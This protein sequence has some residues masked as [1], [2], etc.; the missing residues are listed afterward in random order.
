[1]NIRAHHFIKFIEILLCVLLSH[2]FQSGML[3]NDKTKPNQP[4]PW[5]DLQV[6][7]YTGNLFYQRSDLLIPTRGEIPLH[8]FFSYNSLKHQQDNGYGNGWSFCFGMFYEEKGEDIIIYREEGEEDIF[9]WDST[10]FVPPIGVYDSLTEYDT[11]KYILRTKHGIKYYF[12]SS[13]HKRLTKIIDRNGNT[14]TITYT[15]GRPTTITDPAGRLLTLSWTGEHLSQVTDPNTTPSRIFTYQYDT[16]WN[17]VKVTWPLSNIY[18]YGYDSSG[19]LTSVTDPRS[20]TVTISYDVNEAVSGLS[21]I[22]VNYNK[23]FVY[24]NCN[25]TT[26]VNQIVST[27]SRLTVYTY[28]LT[29][30][31][32]GILNPDSSLIYY[33]WDSLNNVTSF[34]NENGSSTTYTHDTKGNLMSET[35]CMGGT[36]SHTYESVFNK[37]TSYKDKRGYL[38]TYGYD[39]NGN[40]TSIMDCYNNTETFTFNSYGNVIS[41]KDKNNKTTTFSYDTYGNQT[42]LTDPL[43]F[44]ETRTYDLTGNML[45]YTDKR[46]KATTYAYD[47]LDRNTGITDAL[48]YT[49]SFTY[50]AN[51]NLTGETNQNSKTTSYAYDPLNRL[52]VITD[53]LG[54]TLTK[55]YDEAGN[56]ISKTNARGFTTSFTFNSRDWLM[57]VTDCLGNSESRTYNTAGDML[58]ST[59]KGGNTTTFTCNCLR[60]R[61]GMIDPNGFTE[62]YA[63]DA[64]GNMTGYTNKKGIPT[65]SV[66]DGLNRMTRIDYAL[67]FTELFAFDP[68]GN[69]TGFTDKN[70]NTIT[71][72]LDAMGRITTITDPLTKTESKAYDGE[73]NMT[74]YTD[75]NGNTTTF[76]YD[77]LGRLVLKTDPLPLGYTESHTYDGVGNMLTSTDR[78]GNTTSRQYDNLNR[79]T[80]MTTPKGY[81][82]ITTYDAIGNRTSFINKN[83]DTTSYTYDCLDRQITTTDPMGNTQISGFNPDGKL[84]SL[85]DKNGNTT[86]WN[87]NCCRLLST[88]DP[89]LFSEYYGYDNFGNMTSLTNKNLNIT[90]YAYDSLNR[91]TTI[92]T[93]MGNQ[94]KDSL[95]GNGNILTKI[96]A[97]LDTINYTYN[98][99]NELIS[100]QYPDGTSVSY[101]YNNNGDLLQSVNTGGIGETI[102]Y[103]Y[104]IYG[105]II[106]KVTNYGTFSKTITHTRDRNGNNLSIISEAGTISY[107]YDADNRITQITDQ[108]GG[109]TTFQCDGMGNPTVVNYPNGISTF[110]T[111]DA[112]GN[113]ISVVTQTTPS[114]P[115]GNP[116]QKSAKTKIESSRE[117]LEGIDYAVVEIISPVSGPGLSEEV[118][119]I[120]NVMNMGTV[121]LPDFVVSYTLDDTIAFTEFVTVPIPLGGF[122]VHTFSQ[123]VDLS[124]PGN[125]YELTACV[126]ATGD[127]YPDNDCMITSITNEITITM[128]QAFNYIYDFNGNKTMETRLDGTNILFEYSNRNEL[129]S[130]Y[131]LT[132]GALNEFTFYPGGQKHTMTVNGIVEYHYLY[133]P[134]GAMLS[135]GDLEFTADNMGNRTSVTD[136][137]GNVIGYSFGYNYDLLQVSFPDGTASYYAYSAQGDKLQQIENGIT[138]Y[139]HCLEKE[140]L[141]E[142]DAAGNPTWV[143]N[144]RLSLT[145]GLATGYYYY[146]GHGTSTLQMDHFQTVLATAFYDSYGNITDSSGTFLQDKEI[147]KSTTYEPLLGIFTYSSYYLPAPWLYDPES[148]FSLNYLTN[149]PEMGP[150]TPGIPYGPDGS[151]PKPGPD[152]GTP[153]DPGGSDPRFDPRGVPAPKPEPVI[154]RCCCCV[155]DLRTPLNVTKTSNDNAFFIKFDTEIDL[156]YKLWDRNYDGDC[157]LEWWE[158]SNMAYT[159]DMEPNTW[160]DMTQDPEMESTFK[161]WKCRDNNCP[162][163]HKLTVI[164]TD[165]PGWPKGYM[166]RETASLVIYFEITVKSTPG[167][168]CDYL[169]MSNYFTVTHE[170]TWGTPGKQEKTEGVPST[171]VR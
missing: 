21:C 92:T 70:G 62:T 109:V 69:Q 28:D 91:L 3:A 126:M 9:T 40:L 14:S 55:T 102:N 160:T 43:T 50:D 106:S 74:S 90:T 27:V 49:R 77:N 137:D 114:P 123:F 103:T 34:T 100:T 13:T 37:M 117:I 10:A 146:N 95:D 56:I 144:P 73:G 89:L 52:S 111:Y 125:T 156:E 119:V 113:V 78:R 2:C 67:G 147:F 155:N 154:P 93:P 129:I 140:V 83:G 26:S 131:N 158:K 1:M 79:Q 135:A 122:Y 72:T 162:P 108:N 157:T 48:N 75:K 98:A 101:S 85:K 17:L 11:E 58:T 171:E 99:R 4:G 134:D 121:V 45:S 32:T 24:N 23:T 166:P 168:D 6:N 46:G 130:E 31:I 142:M 169:S 39:A 51:S 57:S 87:Y 163:P 143:Y 64:E 16:S 141:T 54:G 22:P 104:D 61:T 161:K 148:G 116:G 124:I 18:Q 63:Y 167:C 139:T 42:G 97:N 153:Y 25:N 84:I 20:N 60:L 115:A 29:G 152:P 110:T 47:L 76:T 53:A 127:D 41:A 159:Y 12:E 65:T 150:D 118:P 149:G 133:N 164:D 35:D 80:S 8:V 5:P 96:D 107:L 81:T 68:V 59:D 105:R 136:P 170:I 19:N 138:T 15:D 44:S 128:Y 88:T 151:D 7:T 132:T 38:T 86:T 165:T 36:V 66:F 120:I 94:T 145:G 112:N 71:Y 30:R 82:E 33:A